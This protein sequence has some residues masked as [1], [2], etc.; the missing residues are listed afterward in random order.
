MCIIWP[1]QDISFEVKTA[2]SNGWWNSI[3]SDYCSVCIISS[4]LLSCL[5]LEVNNV[6]LIIDTSIRLLWFIVFTSGTDR[7]VNHLDIELCCNKIIKFCCSTHSVGSRNSGDN[8]EFP[9]RWWWLTESFH[10]IKVEEE[11]EISIREVY[12]FLIFN[13]TVRTMLC[14]GI[15]WKKSTHWGIIG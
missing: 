12:I 9:A 3:S 13:I 2:I 5:N 14:C 4:N 11:L 7:W 10:I 8:P 1:V 15:R 6:F